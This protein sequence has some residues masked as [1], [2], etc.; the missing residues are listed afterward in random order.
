RAQGVRGTGAQRWDYERAFCR[1]LGIVSET[2]QQELRRSQVAMV[3][4]GG[5][6]GVHLM[7]LARLGIERFTI[8]D[9][10]T[11]ELA[12]FN[13]QFGARID[14]LG[15]SKVDV[16]AEEVQR[17]TPDVQLCILR[18]GVCQASLDRFLDGVDLLIDGIDYFA[19]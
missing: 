13:R 6:G 3:G 2:E 11:F 17:V 16:M 18:N 12:N 7:T 10:D 4:M 15:H 19:I 14:T 5:V 8:A 1:N 9:L